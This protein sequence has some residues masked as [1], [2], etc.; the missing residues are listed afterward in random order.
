MKCRQAAI[1]TAALAAIISGSQLISSPSSSNASAAPPS[2]TT[3][4]TSTTA[5]ATPPVPQRFCPKGSTV[6]VIGDSIT[7]LAAPLLRVRLEVEGYTPL[8]NARGGRT[9][10]GGVEVTWGFG[11]EVSQAGLRC[12]VIALGTNDS[13]LPPD[14]YARWLD[15]LGVLGKIPHDGGVMIEPVMWIPA[16]VPGSPLINSCIP[17]NMGVRILTG[18]QWPA[19]GLQADQVHPN[20]VGRAAWVE[21]AVAGL[22]GQ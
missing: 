9:I 7:E 13:Y 2:S 15:I 14:G 16:R 3:T 8:I 5:S 11:E 10:A 22:V 21:Y 1:L 6:V 17:T 19:N 18:W 20:D 4:T 12:W